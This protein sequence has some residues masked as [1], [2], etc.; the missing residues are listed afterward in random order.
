MNSPQNDPLAQIAHLLP[1]EMQ[2]QRRLAQQAAR[3]QTAGRSTAVGIGAVL[4]ALFLKFKTVLVFLL[5]FKWIALGAKLLLSFGTLVVSIFAWAQMFG[6]WFATGFVLLILVHEM[7]HVIAIRAYGLK[8][9]VPIFVPFIGAFVALKEMPPNSK[10]A[11]VIA[12]A[13]PALGTAGALACYGIGVY[14]HA[15]IWYALASTAFFINLF[16]L[17]PI[18]PLDG[19]RVAAA[20]FSRT[21]PMARGDKVLLGIQAISL[22]LFLLVFWHV[23]GVAAHMT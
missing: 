13:G 8:A 5:G 9:S 4:L 19:G 18:Y 6:L 23:A 1:P 7:G 17:I 21:A 11:G 12:V 14:T 20:L 15:P 2:Q 3:K 10:A 16:N 22:A